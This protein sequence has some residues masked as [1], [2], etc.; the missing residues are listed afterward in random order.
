M[1]TV[2][3][4][5]NIA[6]S[7]LLFYI[8]WRVWQVKERLTNI[9]DTLT[10]AERNT[11]NVLTRAPEAIY[12]CQESISYL[13]TTNQRL[14][15]QMQQIRKAL[16]LLFLAQRLGRIYYRRSHFTSMRKSLAK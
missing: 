7:L 16:Q 9:A 1:L 13:R 6:I 12:Q 2:V 15:L 14:Q 11:Y 4:I 5:I 10:A 3:V 8:A